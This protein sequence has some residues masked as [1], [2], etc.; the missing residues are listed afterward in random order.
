M[1][2]NV[3]TDHSTGKTYVLQ[4]IGEVRDRLRAR[5]Q[6]CALLCLQHVR[7]TRHGAL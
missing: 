3:L 5:A 7:R 2:Q 1:E 4:E 6:R